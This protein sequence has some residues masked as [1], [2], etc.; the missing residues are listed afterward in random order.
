MGGVSLT[1]GRVVS[2]GPVMREICD[3][4]E[5][6]IANWFAASD[7]PFGCIHL[8]IRL[9]ATAEKLPQYQAVDALHNEL[10]VSFVA[11]MDDL[12]SLDRAALKVALLEVCARTLEDIGRRYSAPLPEHLHHNHLVKGSYQIKS[13][14]GSD[15]E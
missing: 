6:D 13:R 7:L 5:S 12:Q 11:S 4:L 8:V 1:K 9:G 14:G 10:P 15:L 3:Q 2:F